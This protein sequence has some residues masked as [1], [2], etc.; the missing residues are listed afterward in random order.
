CA[1]VALAHSATP[2]AIDDTKKRIERI[3]AEIASLE[4]EAAGGA[5]HAE[6]L[7]ELRGTR[8]TALEQL[9]KDEARYE[10][11]RAIVAE[12]TE[13]RE[14]LDKARGPSEDGQPVDVQATR[15]KLA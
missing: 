1:K 4:R 14:T 3:D 10:A 15:D 7:G 11:E 13:L 9:A 5:S 6:R 8:A 2:A 12:I